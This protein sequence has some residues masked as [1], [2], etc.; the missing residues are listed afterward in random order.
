MHFSK[1][2]RCGHRSLRPQ[3]L[4]DAVYGDIEMRN[5]VWTRALEVGANDVFESS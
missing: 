4:G 1:A 2:D 5:T 3:L